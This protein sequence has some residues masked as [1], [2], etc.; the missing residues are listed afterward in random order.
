MI[1][2]IKKYIC[3]YICKKKKQQQQQQKNKQTTCSSNI[4]FKK[5]TSSH[6][7]FTLQ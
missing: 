2:N 5:N 1:Q 6:I 3:M 7:L 4:T